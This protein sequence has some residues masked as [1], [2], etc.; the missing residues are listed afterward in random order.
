MSLEALQEV[1][2]S[3]QEDEPESSAP[4]ENE[5]RPKLDFDYLMVCWA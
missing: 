1:E 3:G 2:I 5:A 4:E